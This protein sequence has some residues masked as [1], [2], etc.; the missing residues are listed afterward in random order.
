M[1]ALIIQLAGSLVISGASA[2]FGS[3][4]G[5]RNALEKLRNERAFERRLAWYE[6]TVVAMVAARDMCLVYAHATRQRDASLLGQLA[7]QM[8]TLFQALGEKAN[9]VV[10]YAPKR[11]VK[12]L[13]V[14]VKELVGLATETIQ[15]LQRGQLYEEFAKHVDTLVVSLNQVIF[16]LA[17][18]VRGELGIEKIELS[19]VQALSQTPT[20]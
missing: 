7:P 18:E 6:D 16:D 20:H 5:V 17:Q 12:R 3:R 9:K 8:V 11:T 19:D 14:L 10:L 1:D 4:L 15:T 2:W 13:D